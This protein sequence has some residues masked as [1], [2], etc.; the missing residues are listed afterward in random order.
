MSK[1]L[2]SLPFQPKHVGQG[3]TSPKGAQ[4]ADS[5]RFQLLAP[6]SKSRVGT[7]PR[8]TGGLSC[9]AEIRGPVEDS[10]WGLQVKCLSSED[11]SWRGK[12]PPSRGRILFCPR[13]LD[14]GECVYACEGD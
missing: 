9:F 11:K 13:G 14:E 6:G 1:P 4:D 8:I 10:G 5:T 2:C 12:S 7:G 3:I